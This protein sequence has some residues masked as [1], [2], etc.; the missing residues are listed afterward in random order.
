MRRRDFVKLFAGSAAA[1]LLVA[2][3]QRPERMRRIGVLLPGTANDPEYQVR[4][5]AFTESL[6]QLGWVDGQN[7]RI[8]IRWATADSD[9]RRKSMTELVTLAQTSFSLLVVHR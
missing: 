7:I 9:R 8:D 3:A 2:W 6:T 5:A 4:M 1:W